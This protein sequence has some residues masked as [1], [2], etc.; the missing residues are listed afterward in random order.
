MTILILSIA[1]NAFLLCGYISIWI[2]RRKEAQIDKKIE[3]E[4]GAMDVDNE[5]LPIDQSDLK[6]LLPSPE[7]LD[8][9]L[10]NT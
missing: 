6:D 3:A 4:I 7:E 5:E 9:L 1:L 2:I 10:D 8:D